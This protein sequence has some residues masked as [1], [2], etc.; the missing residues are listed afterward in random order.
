MATVSGQLALKTRMAVSAGDVHLVQHTA[1]AG[2]AAAVAPAPAAAAAA[3]AAVV[4]TY[5]FAAMEPATD[6]LPAMLPLR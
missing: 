1:Q 3:E 5:S 2:L 4:G 6:T